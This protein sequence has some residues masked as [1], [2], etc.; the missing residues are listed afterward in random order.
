MHDTH[1]ARLIGGGA[2]LQESAISLCNR[3]RNPLALPEWYRSAHGCRF[4]CAT[5]RRSPVQINSNSPRLA[6]FAPRSGVRPF[7]LVAMFAMLPCSDYISS[8]PTFHTQ[9]SN[10]RTQTSEP[11]GPH[12]VRAEPRHVRG[13]QSLPRCA[14]R[15]R[16]GR[17]DVGARSARR[18]PTSA[19]ASTTTRTACDRRHRRGS[20]SLPAI[21]GTFGR[22]GWR[23]RSNRP[24]SRATRSS[25]AATSG[26]C[27]DRRPAG[28]STRARTFGSSRIKRRHGGFHRASRTNRASGPGG[29]SGSTGLSR[30]S[31]SRRPR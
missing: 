8:E 14:G 24:G 19:T 9:F 15:V 29:P 25:R 11:P 3:M 1:R 23:T 4:G 6:R 10:E 26:D 18:G 31:A 2:G 13:R 28:R 12:P 27:G 22:G 7:R 20:P 21:G 17:F 16:I 30:H 5:A